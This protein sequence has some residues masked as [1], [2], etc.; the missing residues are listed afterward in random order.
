[1]DI[2]SAELWETDMSLSGK[3]KML[4]G[5]K[6]KTSEMGSHAVVETTAEG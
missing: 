2:D 6:V 5:G 3:L 4:F 1:L